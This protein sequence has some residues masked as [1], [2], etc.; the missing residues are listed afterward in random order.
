[1]NHVLAK[2]AAERFRP[3]VL[4]KM[5]FDSFDEISDYARAREISQA[6]R[7]AMKEALD[8]YE[9]TLQQ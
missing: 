9:S 4:A 6:G 8:R 3:E 1:M 5:T 7:I 2:N